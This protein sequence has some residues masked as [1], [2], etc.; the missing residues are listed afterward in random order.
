MLF[1]FSTV[2]GW[3]HYGATSCA[4]LF[5][6]KSVPIFRVAFVLTVYGGAVMGD[7]LVWNIADTMNGLMLLPNL[8]GVLVL[9]PVVYRCTKNYVDR[10][11]RGKKV[12]P[13]LSNFPDIQAEQAAALK[14]E[15][16]Q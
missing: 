4:F 12:E 13:M 14:A 1:A 6:E 9:S 5:G 15:E 10:R 11:L 8:I 16:N 7:N 2:L 3:S